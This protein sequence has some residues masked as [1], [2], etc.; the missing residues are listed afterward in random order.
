MSLQILD[1]C[2]VLLCLNH[3][4][5]FVFSR[6]TTESAVRPNGLGFKVSTLHAVVNLISNVPVPHTIK[7]DISHLVTHNSGHNTTV[8][9]DF[10]SEVIHRSLFVVANFVPGSDAVLFV[11]KFALATD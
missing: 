5:K 10:A 2:L 6:V 11:L 9:D 8:L 4:V 3:I 7:I 1:V